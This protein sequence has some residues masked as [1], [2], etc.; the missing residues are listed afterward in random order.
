MKFN[1]KVTHRTLKQR[2]G[3]PPESTAINDIIN[4]EGNKMESLSRFDF[5]KALQSD[6]K[7]DIYYI[8]IHIV[9]LL[10]NDGTSVNKE[11]IKSIQ[12][13]LENNIFKEAMDDLKKMIR[14]TQQQ[15]DDDTQLNNIILTI[16]ANIANQYRN[17]NEI[18]K[19]IVPI[20]I[21]I[22]SEYY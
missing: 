14:R 7:K 21:I 4:K 12:T 15:T 2:G 19:L 9:W 11:F 16:L 1:L 17:N 8:G 6:K 10:Q 5:L 22:E 20:P 13:K 18:E 3:A